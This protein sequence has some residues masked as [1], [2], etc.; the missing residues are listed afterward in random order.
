MTDETNAKRA[1]K[2]LI[3]RYTHIADFGP[4]GEMVELF[5]EDGW[6]FARRQVDISFARRRSARPEHT[7]DARGP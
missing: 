1:R 4:G 3:V 6:K 2:E 7:P 5:T